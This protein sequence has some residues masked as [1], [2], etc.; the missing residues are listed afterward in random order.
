MLRI[1]SA[2]AAATRYLIGVDVANT[3]DGSTGCRI[4]VSVAAPVDGNADNDKAA[5]N[6]TAVAAAVVDAT[7]ADVVVVVIDM[8]FNSSHQGGR[9]RRI[10]PRFTVR[11]SPLM[12]TAYCFVLFKIWL[13][14]PTTNAAAVPPPGTTSLCIQTRQ[15]SVISGADGLASLITSKRP[16]PRTF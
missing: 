9:N 2:S 11:V 5:A 13:I 6:G 4:G 1:V 3:A 14:V 7:V 10:W 8:S 12:I 16:A 15:P